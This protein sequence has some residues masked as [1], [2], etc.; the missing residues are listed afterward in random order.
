[1]NSTHPSI[2]IIGFGAFGQLVAQLLVPY[3]HVSIYDQ[4]E[5]ASR[6][7][8]ELE[9]KVI[10]RAEDLYADFLILAVPVQALDMLLVEIAPYIRPGQL[11]VDVCSIKEEPVRL[12]C[13][14]LPGH[15]EILACHPMFGPQSAKLGVAGCQIVL[16]PIRGERWRPLAS[17]LK[18]TLHLDIIITTPEEHD[19]QAALTQGFTHLLAH[20]LSS[21]GDKPRI[22]TRSFDLISEALAL[23]ESDAPEIFEAVTRGNRHFGPLRERMLRALA[24]NDCAS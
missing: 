19:R 4:S 7:A 9:F 10:T 24:A 23:V 8:S 18:R 5:H 21:L 20:A 13:D 1:M 14:T 17:F 3:A 15:A 16:C 11:I 2:T 12:M 22:R 6:A